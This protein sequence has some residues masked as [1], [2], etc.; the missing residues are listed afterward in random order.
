VTVSLAITGNGAIGGTG[1]QATGGAGT[2]DLQNFENL[3]GG[4]GADVLTGTTGNNVLSAVPGNDRLVGW[5]DAQPGGRDGPGDGWL[6][7]RDRHGGREHHRRLRARRPHGH[8]R[9]E[10]ARRWRW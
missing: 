7:Q 10:R 2:D 6:R 1:D 8:R 4:A 9:G 3:T 5:R